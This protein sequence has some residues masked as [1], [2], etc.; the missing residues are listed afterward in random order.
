M[1]VRDIERQM[2]AFMR[3]VD[4]VVQV[5]AEYSGE[6]FVREARQTDTYKDDTGNLRNSIGYLVLKDG[7]QIAESF[8]G[9]V[10]GA[11][12]KQVAKEAA[13][14][15]GTVI[16]GVA[17]MN[18][19]AAVESKGYDVISNSVNTLKGTYKRLLEK[20]LKI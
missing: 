11:A 7:S 5:A 17:G 2:D 9:G 13:P 16:V 14:G 20:N 12:G 10:G 15:T 8:G 1:A 6:S 19:A 3:R 4:Q 18:Y